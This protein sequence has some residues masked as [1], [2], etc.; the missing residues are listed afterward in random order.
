MLMFSKNW[1][2][3]YDTSGWNETDPNPPLSRAASTLAF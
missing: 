2:D 3:W 1:L